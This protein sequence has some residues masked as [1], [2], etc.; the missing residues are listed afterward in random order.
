MSAYRWL[1]DAR[2]ETSRGPES[3]SVVLSD[4]ALAV[5]ALERLS[6]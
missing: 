2:V 6:R 4:P 5:E 3:R 1:R